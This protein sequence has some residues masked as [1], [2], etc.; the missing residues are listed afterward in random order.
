M[1][2]GLAIG[3]SVSATAA[4]QSAQPQESQLQMQIAQNPRLVS[5]YLD[6]AKVYLDQRRYNE[7]EQALQRAL[8]LV[9]AERGLAGQ[10]R[11]T[12]AS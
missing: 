4:A 11:R 2:I 3:L 7:A 12:P 9:Q 5:T 6:L 8:A 10:P 1:L